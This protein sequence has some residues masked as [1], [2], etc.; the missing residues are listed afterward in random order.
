MTAFDAI[1]AERILRI[2][3]PLG[4]DVLLPERMELRE[5]V[6]GSSRRA[7]RCARRRW[8]SRPPI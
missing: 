3:T 5:A 8:S 4:A 1:Q 7:W 2:E 6:G